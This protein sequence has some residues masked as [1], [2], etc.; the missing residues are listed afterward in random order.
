MPHPSKKKLP[1][2][3]TTSKDWDTLPIKKEKKG[4]KEV[5]KEMRER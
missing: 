5:W 2:K 3:Y 4:K 1:Y